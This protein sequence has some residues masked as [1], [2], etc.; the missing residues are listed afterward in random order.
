MKV[1]YNG[2]EVEAKPIDFIER[3]ESWNEYQLTDGKI[4]KIKLVVTRVLKLD[5]EVDKE[6]NPIYVI[7]STNVVAQIE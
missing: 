2:K 3:K 6:G 7:N 1:N 5:T 4:I